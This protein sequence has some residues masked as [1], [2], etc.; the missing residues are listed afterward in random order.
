METMM[1]DYRDEKKNICRRKIDGFEFG[2]HDGE[3]FF[4]SS[5]EFFSIPI[6]S[7]IQ[8]YMC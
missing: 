4:T 8:V 1:I 6:E 7:L 5:G 2:V 3:V